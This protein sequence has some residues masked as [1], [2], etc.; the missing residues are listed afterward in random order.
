MIV[1]STIIKFNSFILLFFFIIHNQKC[2]GKIDGTHISAR[3]VANQQ[4][5]HHGGENI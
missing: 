1:Y 5:P 2:I 3:V 4:V